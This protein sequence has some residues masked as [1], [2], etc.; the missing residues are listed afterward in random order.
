VANNESQITS[1]DPVG[2]DG[3]EIILD[4]IGY[5]KESFDCADKEVEAFAGDYLDAGPEDLSVFDPSCWV[6]NQRPV[7]ENKIFQLCK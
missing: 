7:Q 4:D 2:S 3:E 6:V 5:L 1:E